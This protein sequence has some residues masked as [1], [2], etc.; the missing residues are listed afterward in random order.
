[1]DV[2]RRHFLQV[3]GASAAGA[4]LFN[5][6]MAP[7]QEMLIQSP[8]MLPEDTVNSFENFYA[9][10]CQQCGA[11]CGVV[12]RVV[13]GRAKK[14]EGNPDHPLNQGK[15]CA[16]GQAGVQSLYHPDRIRTPLRRTGPRGS[17]RFEVISWDTGLDELVGR[18]KAL[19]DEG[20]SDTVAMVTEP[21]MGLQATIAQRFADTYGADYL[22]HQ[23]MEDTVLYA[24][25]SQ[26]FGEDRIPHFDIERSKYV[27]SI[28]ANFLE[29][30]ISQVRYNRAYGEFRQG[31]SGQRGYLVQVEPRLSMTAANADEWVPINPGT[32]GIFAMGIAYVLISEGLANAEAADALTGGAGASALNAYRPEAAASLTGIS[33]DRII[34]IARSFAEHQPGIALGGAGAASHSNGLFNLNAIYALNFLVGS[35]GRRGGIMMNGV[36]PVFEFATQKHASPL[37]TWQ[38]FTQ[39]IASKQPRP[40]N[41]LMVH[42][43]NPLYGLP[44]EVGFGQALRN[45]PVIVSFSSFMDET[46]AMA[47]LILPDHVYLEAWGDV[48]PEPGAGYQAIGFQQP[49]VKPALNTRSFMDAL[50]A[51]GADLGGLMEKV[52]PWPT[53]LDAMRASAESLYDLGRGSVRAPDFEHFWNGA[54][55][56]GGWWDAASTRTSKPPLPGPLPQQPVMPRFAGSDADYPFHLSIFPGAG[57]N[58][59]RGANLPWLQLTPDPT[60]TV[61]WQ[62][63]V[64][65]NP[66]TAAS[67]GIAT[68]DIVIVTSPSGQ[69]EAPVYVY[70]AIP[71][72]VVG[73]PAGQGHTY[74]GRYAEQRGANPL[75]ILAPM[76]ESE[77]GALAW[78]A[79]R[80]QLTRT[81]RQYRLPKLEGAVPAVEPDDYDL[82]QIEDLRSDS[83]AGH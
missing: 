62:T 26:L 81:G 71:P 76:Q 64:E 24:S 35:V 67:M 65:L 63:W 69:L 46:T 55:Q 41:V 78:S 6:C 83:E 10:V 17:G 8:V 5:G 21:L 54:L 70:P 42:N 80:V 73:I 38:Q 1:M 40:V 3:T 43:A 58:D 32:E 20:M 28:G 11:G 9:S 34:G 4:V 14:I 52:L 61:S 2:S 36:P 25:M 12:V 13:E 60:S 15:L 19:S 37:S 23:P 56:R 72:N 48:V 50:L 33:A 49:V 74:F 45:I 68:N 66:K 57:I 82:V 75:S 29:P 22:V 59:G 77:T 18:L 7:E 30:W 16:R 53:Y 47:D 27:L 39:R 31:T 44:V 51:V 79:T